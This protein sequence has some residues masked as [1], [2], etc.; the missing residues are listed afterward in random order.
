MTELSKQG[1]MNLP[2]LVDKMCHAPARI[3]GLKDRG[4]IREGYYADL[5][6]LED[7]EWEVSK[8]NILYKCGWSPFE[9]QSFSTRV[10][11]TL[12][13]GR[14]VYEWDHERKEHRIT[15]GIPGM[16]LQYNR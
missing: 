1:L 11:C 5:V 7:E 15:E 6:I 13:N 16:R 14:V 4:F 10:A 12:V 3:F 2:G 9:G 8:D